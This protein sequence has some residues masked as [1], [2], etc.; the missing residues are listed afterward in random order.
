MPHLDPEQLSLLALYDDWQDEDSREHLRT[1][2]A[3][4]ADYAALRRAVHAVKVAPD[5]S[6]LET[7]GPHVWEGIHR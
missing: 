2:S 6:T 7:P 4:A 3:C 1:C 5:T